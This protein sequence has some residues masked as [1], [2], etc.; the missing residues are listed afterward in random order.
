LDSFEKQPNVNNKIECSREGIKSSAGGYKF[1][2]IKRLL[3]KF[4]NTPHQKLR[5]GAT[6]VRKIY[7]FKP[8]SFQKSDRFESLKN[9]VILT[10]VALPAAQPTKYAIT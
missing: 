4:S 2:L 8:V 3:T 7:Y 10:Y 6:Q 1:M 9:I 5:C